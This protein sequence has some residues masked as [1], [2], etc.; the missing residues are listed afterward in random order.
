VTLLHQPDAP[1]GR[2]L[3]LTHGAGSNAGAPLLVAVAEA[4]AAAGITVLR[5][6]L[7]FRQA[8]PH[9][10]PFPAAAAQDR[11]GLRRAV[12][13]LRGSAFRAKSFLEAIRMAAGRRRCW[14]RRNLIAGP[15]ELVAIESAGHDLGRGAGAR[16]AAT[17]LEAFQ[18]FAKLEP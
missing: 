18:R 2:G 13:V 10:P 14:R 15:H 16:A 7:P 11:A 6:D 12:M 3:V 8:R 5:S 1:D 4:L 17:V 9:G